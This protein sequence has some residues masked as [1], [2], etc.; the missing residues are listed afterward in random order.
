LDLKT[1]NRKEFHFFKN[2]PLFHFNPAK[3]TDGPASPSFPSFRPAPLGLLAAQPHS[4]RIGPLLRGLAPARQPATAPAHYSARRPAQRAY[5][6]RMRHLPIFSRCATGP[7]SQ[8]APL[9]SARPHAFY[10]SPSPRCRPHLS[11]ATIPFPSSPRSFPSL[12]RRWHAP[13]RQATA[14]VAPTRQAARARLASGQSAL[15]TFHP[16][17]TPG[18]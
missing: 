9:V 4:S 3:E 13:E 17:S 5:A 7:A 18:L 6:R 12:P 8:L 15:L 1:K 2:L 14:A 11:A 10:P 16:R